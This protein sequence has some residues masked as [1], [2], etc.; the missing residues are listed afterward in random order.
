MSQS[1]AEIIAFPGRGRCDAHLSSALAELHAALET[2]RDAVAAWR[3]S[4]DELGGAAR[5][6]EANLGRYRSRLGLLQ[7]EL[8]VLHQ[9]ASRLRDWAETHPGSTSG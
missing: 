7:T 4:I 2:Q 6:I 9:Q 1:G 8:V 3:A 5:S